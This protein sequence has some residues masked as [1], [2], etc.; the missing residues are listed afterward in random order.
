MPP[1]K[2]TL[3]ST[4]ARGDLLD[5]AQRVDDVVA[6][7]VV[8]DRR[9]RVPAVAGDHGG[10]A[11]RRRRRDVG[12]PE[13]VGVEVRVRVDEA[14][15]EHEAAAVDLLASGARSVAHHRDPVA[16]D[17]DVGLE[18]GA[19]AA[20]EHERAPHHQVVLALTRRSSH[21]RGRLGQHAGDGGEVGV[22]RPAVAEVRQHLVEI[23]AEELRGAV[24]RGRR[25][26]ARR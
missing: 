7:G 10:H 1:A 12:V 25:A 17:G 19:A 8:G 6:R 13:E 21:R 18:P 23:D 14:G 2:L 15:R 22:E 3:S 11:E 9:E 20:V 16:V 4:A 24:R 5:G 26:S